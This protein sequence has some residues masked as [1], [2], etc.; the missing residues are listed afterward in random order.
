MSR[1][2]YSCVYTA[3]SGGGGA[4]RIRIN[5]ATGAATIEHAIGRKRME[6]SCLAS[7]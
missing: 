2:L 4:G 5:T 7:I 3:S 1:A 6:T